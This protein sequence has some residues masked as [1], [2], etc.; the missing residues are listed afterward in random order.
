MNCYHC[1]NYKSD[2]GPANSSYCRAFQATLSDEDNPRGAEEFYKYYNMNS[3]AT[4]T[5]P[6]GSHSKDYD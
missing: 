6:N 4:D 3:K 2:H 5:C 1:P